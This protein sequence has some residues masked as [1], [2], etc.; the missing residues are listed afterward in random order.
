MAEDIAKPDLLID[1]LQGDRETNIAAFREVFFS[2][3][4]L[5]VNLDAGKFSL[6]PANVTTDSSQD[7][8][9]LDTETTRTGRCVRPGTQTSKATQRDRHQQH[10]ASL[11]AL[12]RQMTSK[13][14]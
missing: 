4:Y 13:A 7:L 3:A 6:W 12:Q 10:P 11:Q 1:C 14:N 9:A 5:S 8:R 2:A